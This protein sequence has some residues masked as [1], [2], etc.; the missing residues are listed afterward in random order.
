[1][2]PTPHLHRVVYDLCRREWHRRVN[3]MTLGSQGSALTVDQLAER[4]CPMRSLLPELI[5]L[6]HQHQ[7]QPADQLRPIIRRMIEERDFLDDCGDPCIDCEHDQ[8]LEVYVDLLVHALE[9]VRYHNLTRGEW[10]T[11]PVTP[12]MFG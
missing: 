8:L 5:E 12:Q 1:M 6:M 11:A 4:I 3:R 2:S 10:S 7:D 9:R